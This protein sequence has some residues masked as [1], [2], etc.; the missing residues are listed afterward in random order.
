MLSHNASA[1]QHW[2]IYSAEQRALTC[3]FGWI[4]LEHAPLSPLHICS[5]IAVLLDSAACGQISTLRVARRR[6]H[7][8][9]P[10]FVATPLVLP[11]L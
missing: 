8:P 11:R 4:V 10:L 9:V 6:P 7:L 5:A 2:P 1:R 3:G